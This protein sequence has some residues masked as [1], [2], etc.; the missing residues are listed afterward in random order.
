MK[1]QRYDAIDGL[2]AY[3][4]I[5]VAIM[6]IKVNGFNFPGFISERV[7]GEMGNFVFLF[8]VISAFSMCCGYYDKIVQNRITVVEF[9]GKRYAKIWPFWALIC[10]LDLVLSPELTTLY[11]YFAD[12]TLCFGFLP[13]ANISVIGVGWFLGLVF[14]FYLLFPFF[15]YLISD[16]RRAWFSFAAALVFNLICQNYFFDSEH[17][18]ETFDVRTNIL[19]C[20]VFFLA[21]GLIYIYRLEIQRFSEKMHWFV[22]VCC[23]IMAVVYFAIGSSVFTLLAFSVMLLIYAIGDKKTTGIL[24]NTVTKFISGISMEI[25]LC[26]M[27]IYRIVEKFHLLYMFEN[28]ILSYIFAVILVITGAILFSL[29]VRWGINKFSDLKKGQVKLWLKR[30]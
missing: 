4:A 15:C 2:R 13:N 29:V 20:A 1:T 23:I 14:V 6:H 3:A 21:G 26:H 5:G 12:I 16:K 30:N 28:E 25:Y 19:Y 11:E 8:M 7:I 22:L 24:R 10:T 27:V 9:F 18:V 17:V